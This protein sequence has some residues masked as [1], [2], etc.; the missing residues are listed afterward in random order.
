MTGPA[1]PATDAV[2]AAVRDIR[3]ESRALQLYLEICARCGTC[4]QVCHVYQ[5]RRSRRANP[6]RRSDHLRSLYKLA[7]SP[8]RRA[9]R[10]VR[11]SDAE[12]DTWAREF[13]ECSGCR[14]CARFCPLG[15]DN[16][17]ITRKARAILHSLGK[18]P[19]KIAETQRISDRYGN[20]E[21]QPVP[22]FF[23]SI[24]F[25]EEEML[26]ESGIPVK[27]PVDQPTDYLFV[28]ASA[29]LLSYPDTLMGCAYFFHAAGLSWSMSSRSFDSANFGL[30]SGDDEH[31]KRKA[32][33]MVD[34][35]V[36]LGAKTLVIGECGHATR[37]AKR[38][39]PTFWGNLPFEI[40][41]IFT[42]ACEALDAGKL[43]LDPFRNV[44]RV[45]Y[46][47]PCNTARSCGLVEEPR[48]LLA[49][50]VTDF[51][52]MTPTRH[53]NW[54][55]GGGGGLAVMDGKEGLREMDCTFLEFR[56]NVAGKMKLEQIRATGAGYVATAC[57]NCKRQLTQLMEYHGT[58]VEVGGVFDLFAK[59]VVL[60][61]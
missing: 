50:C 26:E 9:L 43:R 8:L 4:A 55:C 40:K 30:F 35:C 7:N 52:E 49:A 39:L 44:V 6:A 48:R 41:S 61:P 34:S 12:R 15:I 47:D 16:S 20:D 58:G 21:G 29:D 60:A 14:R 25:L 10:R 36:A 54:C 46:H 3:G 18:S 53:E 5:G 57:A 37:V 42:V 17:V 23:E 31:M 13:Y 33:M 28:P 24:R 27:I 22:A 19:K 45:T 32:R 38:F 11:F 2:L 56:M 1:S 51:R 59:A